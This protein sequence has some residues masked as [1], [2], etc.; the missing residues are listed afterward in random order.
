MKSGDDPALPDK[1]S[2]DSFQST[3]AFPCF[4][5]IWESALQRCFSPWLYDHGVV[6]KQKSHRVYSWLEYILL[7][8][9]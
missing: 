4:G 3:V 1:T 8:S 2:P 9:L 6:G 7:V 5:G